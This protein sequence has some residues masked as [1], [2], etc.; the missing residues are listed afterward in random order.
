[1]YKPCRV[2]TICITASSVMDNPTLLLLLLVSVT[3]AFYFPLV[4]T[5]YLG[6]LRC[7]EWEFPHRLGCFGRSVLDRESRVPERPKFGVWMMMIYF[8][9]LRMH[10]KT[11][12]SLL[13]FDIA[14]V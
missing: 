5:T 10:R 7:E 2:K 14:L 9:M 6:Q 13:D 4:M 1:V 12:A 8:M 11:P 3:Y